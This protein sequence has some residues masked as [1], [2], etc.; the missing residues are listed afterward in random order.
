MIHL[1][2]EFQAFFYPT[3]IGLALGRDVT[4]KENQIE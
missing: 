3:G 2:P 4:V 1:R